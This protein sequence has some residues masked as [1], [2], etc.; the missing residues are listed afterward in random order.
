MGESLRLA[1]AVTCGT[2]V[3]AQSRDGVLSFSR[4]AEQVGF[5]SI[6]FGDHVA[7][8]VPI[9]EPLTALAFAAAATERVRLGTSVYLL[10]LRHPTVTA[11]ATATLDVLSG[12]RLVLGVGV[13]GE[14]PAEF[15]ACGVPVAERGTRADE[16]IGVLRRLWA[17]DGVAHEGR[18]FRF[19]PVTLEPKPVQPGGPRILVGGRRARALRRAGRLGDG[20]LSHMC[21]PSRYAQNLDEIRR[22]AERAGR[23]EVAFEAA[24]FLFACLG[25][26]YEA[27]A[28]SA[29]K[30]LSLVYGRPFEE[31]ARRY[32]LLGRTAD[33]LEQMR[34]F[35]RAGC[36]SFVLSPLTPPD[37]FLEHAREGILPEIPALL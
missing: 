3:T 21:S 2:V 7:F 8:Q 37:A 1:D 31:A 30:T 36:R 16:A 33:C 10:P 4:R 19:G 35:V 26:D 9:L 29:G 12:G 20:F 25:D 28:T 6:W 32:C 15:E 22:H 11:K 24:A 23:G 34:A 27:C 14:F 13:G 18:H 5:D 17:E